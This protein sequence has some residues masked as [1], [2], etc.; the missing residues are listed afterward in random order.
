MKKDP[1]RRRY[2]PCAPRAPLGA[3]IAPRRK[4]RSD[5]GPN[6]FPH[7]EAGVAE[8]FFRHADFRESSP[9]LRIML[10]YGT[11]CALGDMA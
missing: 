4:T 9:F 8:G 7:H 2:T 5:G 11:P 10:Q 1:P 6:H 3:A